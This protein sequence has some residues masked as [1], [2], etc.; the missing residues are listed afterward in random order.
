MWWRK[1]IESP[2]YFLLRI[3]THLNVKAEGRSLVIMQYLRAVFFFS[4]STRFSRPNPWPA[5]S[6]VSV[7][8]IQIDLIREGHV[9]CLCTRIPY[10]M[11]LM[12][13]LTTPG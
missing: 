9:L 12:Q 3:S 8:P 13:A 11:K 5:L 4:S 6:R 2:I 10:G 1:S 7:K